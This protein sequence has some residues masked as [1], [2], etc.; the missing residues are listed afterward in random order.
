ML[1]GCVKGNVDR[2]GCICTYRISRSAGSV[3]L[4]RHFN[5]VMLC[6]L[7][8]E[9][10]KRKTNYWWCFEIQ[11]WIMVWM[12]DLRRISPTAKVLSETQD[13]YV[14][15]SCG[16]VQPVPSPTLN[17]LCASEY[18]TNIKTVTERTNHVVRVQNS[19]RICFVCAKLV[20]FVVEVFWVES[21][22][23]N[24]G[25]NQSCREENV[26]LTLMDSIQRKSILVSLYFKND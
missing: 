14:E 15:E 21:Q 2:T 3:G 24:R 11:A 5:D 8:I 25:R 26:K 4:F 6:C 23:I 12:E 7:K 13:W 9:V 20:V 19:C 17:T 22:A 16:V 10:L 18:C 1:T